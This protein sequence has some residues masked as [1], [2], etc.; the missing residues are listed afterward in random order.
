MKRGEIWWVDLGE[1]RGSAPGY[2][3]PGVI[4]S[5]DEYNDSGLD[6]VLVVTVTTAERLFDMPGNVILPARGTGLKQE[7]V[8]NVTQIST[9]DRIDLV[10]RIGRVPNALMVSI[11]AGLRQ[12][13]SL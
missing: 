1:P 10:R 5:N 13:M 12:V 8:V 2:R 3:R 4:V 7:S 9:V 6:T 11:D